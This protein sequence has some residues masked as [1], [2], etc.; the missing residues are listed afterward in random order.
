MCKL[1]LSKTDIF[2]DDESFVA[3][4]CVRGGG[5]VDGEDFSAGDSFFVPA[6]AG[7]LTLESDAEADVIII[8]IP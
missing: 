4:T 1:N 5:R 8:S 6:G 2:V 7:E 3:L